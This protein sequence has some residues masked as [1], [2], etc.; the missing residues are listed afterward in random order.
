MYTG[1][2]LIKIM[3]NGDDDKNNEDSVFHPE[4]VHTKRDGCTDEAKEAKQTWYEYCDWIFSDY[5]FEE[6]GQDLKIG[7]T[8]NAK[9]TWKYSGWF[10]GDEQKDYE[11]DD[12]DDKH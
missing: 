10:W 5:C 3:A 8:R 11:R 12:D 6:K 4:T 2:G 1:K 7:S 9:K